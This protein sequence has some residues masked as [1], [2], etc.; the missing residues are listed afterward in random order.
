MLKC[1]GFTLIELMV[2]AGIIVLFTGL[3]LANYKKGGQQFALQ[4]SANKLAQDIRRAE[5]MAMSTEECDASI[6]G[7]QMVPIGGYGIHLSKGDKN[8]LLYADIN[9]NEKHG[10]AD[11]NMEPIIDLEKKIVINDIKDEDDN[12]LNFVSINFKPPDP[13]INL[14]G[15]AGTYTEVKIIIALEDD[16][17]QEKTITINKA[18]L[19][20][21]E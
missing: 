12:S 9:G 17:T 10:G 16:L 14:S 13:I 20:E 6:C 15:Q 18:G 11:P 19:V 21:I 3:M 4:R 2:L 1:K 7:I 5:A 8:Y